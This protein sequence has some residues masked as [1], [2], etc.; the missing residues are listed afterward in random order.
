MSAD[1][2]ERPVGEDG[3]EYDEEG[4]PGPSTFEDDDDDGIFDGEGDMNPDH[5]L[6]ARYVYGPGTYIIYFLAFS[7]TPR[8][9]IP[10]R[11]KNN[12]LLNFSP[13]NLII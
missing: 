10:K 7:E 13:T 3:P 11:K 1:D 4:A 2:P 9:H 6:L 5:P 8:T 12:F